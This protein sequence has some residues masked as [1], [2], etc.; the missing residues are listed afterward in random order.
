M[1]YFIT[2]WLMYF[3]NLAWVIFL[4]LSILISPIVYRDIRYRKRSIIKIA[5]ELKREVHN[6]SSN[7]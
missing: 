1:T 6:E 7:T 3:G 5:Y 2:G 4:P